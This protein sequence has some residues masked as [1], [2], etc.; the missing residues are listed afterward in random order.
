MA[1]AIW[2]GV[3]SFGLVSVPVG[4]YAATEQH[5]VDFHQFQRGTSDRIRYRRVNE[6]TGDEVPYE[7]I[8]KGADIGGGEFVIVTPEELEQVAPGRSRALE[9]HTFVDLDEVDPVFFERTYYLAPT[10]EEHQG[11]YALLR[12]AMAAQRRAAIGTFVMRDKEHL[13]AIRADGEVLALEVMYFADEVRS[14]REALPLLPGDVRAP[15]RE[16]RLAEQLVA[17]MAGPWTPEAYHDSY[18]ERVRELVATKQ[19]GGVVVAAP[20]PP[21][22][23][24]VADLMELLQRSVS[25][26]R[27]GG[28][29]PAVPHGDQRTAEASSGAGHG[30]PR[31]GADHARIDGHRPRRGRGGAHHEP[32]EPKDMTLTQLRDVARDLGVRGRSSMTRRQL[33]DAVV[34]ARRRRVS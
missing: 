8:V 18:T 15:E 30:A 13:A 4:V 23:S 17:S 27:G 21:A 33:A 25:E 20:E 5:E 9:I 6:R 11:A 10:A 22:A 7:D 3:I 2:T 29:A 16:A 32:R 24:N 14:P 26:R 28:D 34:K 31:D 19:R 12:D 1:R